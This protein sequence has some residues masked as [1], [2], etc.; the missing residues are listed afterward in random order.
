GFIFLGLIKCGDEPMVIEYNVRMGD[1]ETEVVMP[2]LKS[3]LIDLLEAAAQGRLREMKAETDPR[4]CTTVMMVSGGYPGAYE[5]GK[6]MNG[7]GDVDGNSIA[8]HAGTKEDGKGGIVTSGGRVIAVSSLGD[9]IEDA[10][11]KS[12]ANV[13]RISFD[14]AFYRKDIGQDMIRIRDSRK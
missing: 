12:Y 3:D 5:K 8:F 6:T 13:R 1:P 9:S 11:A 2:R 7:L 10:L 14:G 4:T